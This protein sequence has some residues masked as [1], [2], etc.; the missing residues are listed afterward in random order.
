MDNLSRMVATTPLQKQE[1]ITLVSVLIC[2]YIYITIYYMIIFQCLA[3]KHMQ[4]FGR[5]L[6]MFIPQHGDFQMTSQWMF[7]QLD[8][9]LGSLKGGSQP[10]NHPSARLAKPLKVWKIFLF[11]RCSKR[12]MFRATF[13]F[14]SPF[15]GGWF[16]WFS[17]L[18][19]DDFQG[20]SALTAV[21]NNI[22]TP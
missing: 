22:K 4:A 1:I 20:F 13:P 18:Q 11:T 21:N 6:D 17:G 5:F 12:M 14:T 7:V 3:L 19:L 9:L 15:Q 2:V 10:C 16:S 8:W